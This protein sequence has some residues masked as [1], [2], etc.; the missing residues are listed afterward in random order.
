MNRMKNHTGKLT[1]KG[2]GKMADTIFVD[3]MIVKRKPKAPDFVKCS[4][5]F[6]M[7]DFIKFARANHNDG[8]LNVDIK[9]SKG[10]KLYAELDTWKPDKR[11][12]P[13]DD[14]WGEQTQA[15]TQP[16]KQPASRPNP[17]YSDNPPEPTGDIPF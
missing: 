16:A 6:K 3:G 12:S 13:P 8:W 14:E 1:T 2:V 17:E 4:L 5:S 9:L 7:A 11:E 15:T 10:G